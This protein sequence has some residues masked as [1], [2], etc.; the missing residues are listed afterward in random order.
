VK[1]LA[2][3]CIVL[4]LAGTF[5]AAI[6]VD[7]ALA[8][9]APPPTTTTSTDTTPTDTTP[10]TTTTPAPAVAA[11][12]TLAGVQIGGLTSDQAVAAVTDFFGRPVTLRFEH[13]TISV[14][15]NVLGLRV[16]ADT[17]VARAVTVAPGTTLALRVGYDKARVKSFLAKLAARFDR[18]PESSRLLF[19][20]AK[21]LVTKPVIGR[22]LDRVKATTALTQQLVHGTRAT[23]ALRAKLTPPPVTPK[24]IGP[25]VVIKRASNVLTL[26]NGMHVVRKFQ[27]ATGQTI[28]PTPLG[29]FQIVVK[30]KNP[31]WYPPNSPWA[32]NEKPT[33]P[34]PGN[35][36]GTRWMGLSSPGVGIHGTPE[37]GSIGYSLSHGCIRM[38]IP[39]AEWLF[40][41]VNVGTPVFI[42]S[43]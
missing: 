11:G 1:R 20:A 33:P 6:F 10:T 24:T 40:D 42:I 43:A 16:S 41:H 19:R 12:V 8:D 36:L 13:T 34:G 5:A 22:T 23:I 37:S 32:K 30:W 14:S 25:I 3:L 9:T 31:W 26:Y 35:P 17:A 29:R 18:K 39:Q 2:L 7:R 4:L 27:V 38:L 15:P 28:Y 21:P